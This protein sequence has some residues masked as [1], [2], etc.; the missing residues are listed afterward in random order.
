MLC[1]NVATTLCECCDNIVPTLAIVPMLWQH[2]V[3]IVATLVPNVGD[4]CWG[5]IQ[6]TLCE[7]CGNVTLQRWW[8]TLYQCCGNIVWKLWLYWSSTL[9][10]NIETMFRQCCESV[11]AMSLSIVVTNIETTHSSTGFEFKFFILRITKSI[12]LTNYAEIILLFSPN[13]H[14]TDAE[15]TFRQR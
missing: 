13:V 10:I 11:V 2:C 8:P 5:N 1:V 9:V 3:N 6:A 14:G 7:C 12:F 15:T 4:Q